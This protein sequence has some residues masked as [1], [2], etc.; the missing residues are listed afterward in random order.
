MGPGR[1]RVPA[2]ERPPAA[3]PVL[4]LS[5]KG[6]NIEAQAC[7]EQRRMGHRLAS[8]SRRGDLGRRE[9][10]KH[11]PFSSPSPE[12]AE[13]ERQVVSPSRRDP[14]GATGLRSLS[15]SPP[16][17]RSSRPGDLGRR[18]RLDCLRPSAC[19][20]PAILS[21]VAPARRGRRRK[22]WRS[23]P[24]CGDGGPQSKVPA[25][26]RLRHSQLPS[27][28]ATQALAVQCCFFV[29]CEIPPPTLEPIPISRLASVG[30]AASQRR[31]PR[32]AI[33]YIES[34]PSS[35][36]PAGGSLNL[37]PTGDIGIGS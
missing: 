14:F 13:Q 24:A 9:Q 15:Q 22:P 33:L 2:F 26:P 20:L 30:C 19:C 8:S 17:A 35:A 4:Q 21:A 6:S 29:K 12:R 3:P 11:N 1:R 31:S 16:L 25:M 28:P 18:P 32:S 34:P 7:P 37:G 23:L 10:A 5:P 27:H 36:S